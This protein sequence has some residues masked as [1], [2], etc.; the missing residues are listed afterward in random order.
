MR[1]LPGT[2][3]NCWEIHSAYTEVGGGAGQPVWS[4]SCPPT[5]T[6]GLGWTAQEASSC[7][8]SLFPAELPTGFVS[9]SVPIV[10]EKHIVS[11]LSFA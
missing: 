7:C 8:W 3:G 5:K 6:M 4:E 1:E 9:L 2:A 11:S 10:P